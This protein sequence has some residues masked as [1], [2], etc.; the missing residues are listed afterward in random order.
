M[1]TEQTTHYILELKPR[2]LTDQPV[3]YWN[4]DTGWETHREDATLFTDAQRKTATVATGGTWVEVDAPAA[5][6]TTC[7]DCQP[8]DPHST[9]AGQV[10]LCPRH[11]SVEK[12]EDELS[13]LRWFASVVWLHYHNATFELD[14]LQQKHLEMAIRC[15]APFSKTTASTEA[16]AAAEERK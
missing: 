5:E 9:Y 14:P 8:A 16:L 3:L 7:S 11:S 4:R 10:F 1:N 15:G 2:A 12:S 6:Q 13:K